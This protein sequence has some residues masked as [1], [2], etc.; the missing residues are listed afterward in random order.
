MKIYKLQNHQVID[1]SFSFLFFLY[2]YIATFASCGLIGV[3]D[4]YSIEK[5]PSPDVRLLNYIAYPNIS[6]NGTS[7][8]MQNMSPFVSVFVMDPFLFIT[9]AMTDE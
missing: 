4:L 2:F 1:Q 3:C 6:L 7:A 8:L 9:P 5:S